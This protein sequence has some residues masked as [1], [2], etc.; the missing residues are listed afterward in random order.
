M[1]ET[2]GTVLRRLRHERGL[3]LEEV[4][5]ATGISVAM[6][7]RA[8]RE[9]RVP[10][11]E[12]VAALSGYYGVP[13][14]VLERYA[15]DLHYRSRTNPR[16]GSR[17]SGSTLE[18]ALGRNEPPWYDSRHPPRAET[19]LVNFSAPQ[20]ADASWELPS[21]AQSEPPATDALQD[22]ARVAEVALQTAMRAAERAK[23]S[24]DPVQIAEAERVIKRLRALLE[25]GTGTER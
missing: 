24:G 16:S 7:S 2:L 19:R 4:A 21:F 17:G 18:P 5:E 13:A 20:M 3:T 15:A 10:S 25:S 14:E 9:Q 1:D 22:A 23:A 12:I 11:T 8:E 6:L